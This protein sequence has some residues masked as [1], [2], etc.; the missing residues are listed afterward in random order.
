MRLAETGGQ[1]QPIFCIAKLQTGNSFRSIERSE[2]F[3]P[4]TPGIGQTFQR[5]HHSGIGRCRTMSESGKCRQ[6]HR[7]VREINRTDHCRVDFV[8]A[9]CARRQMQGGQPRGFFSGDGK[10][11]ASQIKLAVNPVGRNIRHRTDHA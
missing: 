3:V 8:G 9:K 11:R 1:I 7:L 2:Y 6:M 4:V 10:C 5:Q